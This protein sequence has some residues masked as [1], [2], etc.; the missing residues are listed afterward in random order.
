M[1]MKSDRLVLPGKCRAED[2]P[3]RSHYNRYL[4]ARDYKYLEK[5]GTEVILTAI[6]GLCYI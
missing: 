5:L 3:G 1:T 2:C 6:R 4:G